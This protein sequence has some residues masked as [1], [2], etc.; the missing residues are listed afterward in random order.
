[1]DSQLVPGYWGRNVLQCDTLL[2]CSLAVRAR[3]WRRPARPLGCFIAFQHGI[4]LCQYERGVSISMGQLTNLTVTVLTDRFTTGPCTQACVLAAICIIGSTTP[5][6]GMS[7]FLRDRHGW[8]THSKGMAQRLTG[9]TA[10]LSICSTQRPPQTHRT[11]TSR[12][13]I[14]TQASCRR[15]ILAV[16]DVAGAFTRDWKP[17]GGALIA[18]D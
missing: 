2:P 8:V 6:F 5:I 18:Q 15:T 16:A 1:M 17:T 10:P 11:V 12:G 9:K 13:D 4:L 14:L 3:H 7:L